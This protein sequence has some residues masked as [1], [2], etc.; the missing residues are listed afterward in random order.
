M[1]SITFTQERNFSDSLPLLIHCST[2]PVLLSQLTI[3]LNGIW[4]WKDFISRVI[5]THCLCSNKQTKKSRLIYQPP[6]NRSKLF[7]LRSWRRQWMWLLI[8]SVLRKKTLSGWLCLLMNNAS[9]CYKVSFR[10]CDPE[11]SQKWSSWLAKKDVELFQYRAKWGMASSW[12][13]QHKVRGVI[14]SFWS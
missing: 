8:N 12:R 13:V 3:S 4:C 7:F 6:G 11:I 9:L 5:S 14:H 2:Q 10:H 1:A